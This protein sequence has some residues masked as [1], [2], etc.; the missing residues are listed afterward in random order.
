MSSSV[1][2]KHLLC[3]TV[4]QY[5]VNL[6][7]LCFVVRNELDVNTSLICNAWQ[8]DFCCWVNCGRADIAF[9][10]VIT[11]RSYWFYETETIPV[12]EILLA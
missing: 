5:L 12:P 1:Y 6:K 2:F 4:I 10:I 11:I 3:L 9:L 7:L 8:F